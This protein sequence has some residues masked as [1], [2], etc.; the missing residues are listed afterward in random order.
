MAYFYPIGD[1]YFYEFSDSQTPYR[2]RL[3]SLVT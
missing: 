3:I 1:T 2:E